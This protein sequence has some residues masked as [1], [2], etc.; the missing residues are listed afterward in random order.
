MINATQK[1]IKWMARLQK[2][3]DAAPPG[4]WGFVGGSGS[5]IAILRHNKKGQR[6]MTAFGGVDQEYELGSVKAKYAWDGG[7][8]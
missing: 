8:W 7:D 5:H 3:L 2:V 6:V 4:V 1:E